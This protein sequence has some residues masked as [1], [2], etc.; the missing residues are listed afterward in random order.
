LPDDVRKTLECI[1]RLGPDL[2][3]KE[4][5]YTPWPVKSRAFGNPIINPDA[6]AKSLGIK[7]KTVHNHL[8]RARVILRDIFNFDGTFFLGR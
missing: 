3:L 7:R 8:R 4:H 1:G 6:I 5:A 2:A